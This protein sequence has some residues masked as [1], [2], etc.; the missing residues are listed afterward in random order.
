MHVSGTE[1]RFV[2]R[3][4]HRLVPVSATLRSPPCCDQLT[5]QLYGIG[6][7]VASRDSQGNTEAIYLARNWIRDSSLSRKPVFSIARTQEH[8]HSSKS[9]TKIAFTFLMD[10]IMYF[11]SRCKTVSLCAIPCRH[12]I[13]SSWQLCRAMYVHVPTVALA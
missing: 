9:K 12:V 4:F 11:R 7:S 1:P 13:A 3:P 10:V 2:G 8:R 5:T 6:D